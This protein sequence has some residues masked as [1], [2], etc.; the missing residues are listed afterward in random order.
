MKSITTF[1]NTDLKITGLPFGNIPRIME[2]SH[3][4]P[5]TQARERQPKPI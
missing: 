2:S 1:P 4:F 3:K 5:Y